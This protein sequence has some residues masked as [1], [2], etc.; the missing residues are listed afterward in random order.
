[1]RN[2][3]CCGV[4]LLMLSR[5]CWEEMNTTI[6]Q[7]YS[8]TL[9]TRILLSVILLLVLL[10]AASVKLMGGGWLLLICGIPYL[11]IFLLHADCHIVPILRSPQSKPSLLAVVLASH[12]IFIVGFLLQIDY[13]DAPLPHLALT[14]ITWNVL[15]WPPPLAGMTYPAAPAWIARLGLLWNLLVLVPTFVSWPLLF[16]KR[17]YTEK[18]S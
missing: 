8:R 4:S 11:L 3:G 14:N 17:F 7:P 15:N 6:A 5:S 9:I 18:R 2:G 13:S 1:M 12:V 16:Y 10:V